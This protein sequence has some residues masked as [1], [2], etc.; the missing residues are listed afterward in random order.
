MHMLE[1]QLADVRSATVTTSTHPSVPAAA[2][3]PRPPSVDMMAGSGGGAAGMAGGGS[4]GGASGGNAELLALELEME[5]K[6]SAELE[7][8]MVVRPGEGGR[9]GGGYACSRVCS[10]G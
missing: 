6:Y 7:A 9:R 3:I 1:R 8:K 10:S 4:E 2:G 5:R